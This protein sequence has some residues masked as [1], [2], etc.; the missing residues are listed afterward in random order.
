MAVNSNKPEQWKQDIAASIDMY[1]D[2]FM[3]FAPAAFRETR[4]RTA[5]EVEDMLVVT[6]NLTNVGV[7]LLKKRPAML[8]SLR[9]STCPPL[10]RDRLIGLAGVSGNL[11]R[12]MEKYKK[13]PPQMT[14]QE[15]NQNL[16]KISNVIEQM[17]DPDLFV[18]L[19][20]KASPTKQELFRAT[21]IVADRLCGAEANPIVRNAQEKRQL[22]AIDN[23]LSGK[24]YRYISSKEV[25]QFDKLIPG[26][27]SFHLNVIVN[28]EKSDRSINM[29]VDVAVMPKIAK[30]GEL[31][32]L[33]E[34]KSAGDFTNVNKRRKEEATK[35]NQL[36]QTYGDNVRLILFLCGYFDSGYLGYE[37]AERMDW[38]WEHRI[39]DLRGFGL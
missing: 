23:W 37:A 13:L 12:T 6:R 15:L 26:T 21:T 9:M 32:L 19:G 22:S 25:K 38:V 4:D 29:P 36:R 27:Y 28:Q 31:P 16:K 24:D 17:A 33:I 34:A 39:Q 5:K 14:Q 7:E 10:A 3:R 35:I 18:W 20:R 1:N 11:V 2:W 30:Q 8:S